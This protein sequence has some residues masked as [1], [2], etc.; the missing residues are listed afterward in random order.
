MPYKD[1]QKA[2]E[3]K[4]TWRREQRRKRGLQKQGRKPH[5]EEEKELTNKKLLAYRIQYNIDNPYATNDPVNRL[6]WAAKRRSK[7]EGVPF[8]ITKEDIVIPITCPYLG[9]ELISSV[10]RGQQHSAVISL[11][12]IVPALG[13]VQGNIEVMSQ[14]ANTMKSNATKDQLVAFAKE[15]IKRYA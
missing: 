11:D 13:Y 1:K 14:L 10:P 9:I 7:V 8:N 12:K 15:V 6:I 5:T 4:N 2:Q 3:Y